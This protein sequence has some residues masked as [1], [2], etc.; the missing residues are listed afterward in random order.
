MSR[1]LCTCPG[2]GFPTAAGR[3]GE[4][5]A[6][7]MHRQLTSAVLAHPPS[8][9]GLLQKGKRGF[10]PSFLRGKRHGVHSSQALGEHPRETPLAPSPLWPV[11]LISSA[12][13]F[14]RYTLRPGCVCTARAQGFS[15]VIL[16]RTIRY[17]KYLS[18]SEYHKL[19]MIT[20][21][22]DGLST[23]TMPLP[24]R[25]LSTQRL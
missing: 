21:R 2:A 23:N 19:E 1:G 9:P 4:S 5:W 6:G 12:F 13:A 7:R 24:A 20:G 8:K 15:L 3:D 16:H 22:C 18:C 17:N 10:L 14:F 25:D 11:L